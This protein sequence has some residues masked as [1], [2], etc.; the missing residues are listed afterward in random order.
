RTSCHPHLVHP[1][2]VNF[3]CRG[4]AL[5]EEILTPIPRYDTRA[6]A[7]D[8]AMFGQKRNIFCQMCFAGPRVPKTAIAIREDLYLSSNHAFRLDRSRRSQQVSCGR[9]AEKGTI[10]ANRSAPSLPVARTGKQ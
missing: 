4:S 3:L 5:M 10:P 1:L 8:G 9:R 7:R 6:T 2:G